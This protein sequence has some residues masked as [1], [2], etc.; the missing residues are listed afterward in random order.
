MPSFWLPI[1]LWEQPHDVC[2]E[3]VHK[4]ILD[5]ATS[6]SYHT[7]HPDRVLQIHLPPYTSQKQAL[8]FSSPPLP[9]FPASSWVIPPHSH[10]KFITSA[11]CSQSTLCRSCPSPATSR[12]RISEDFI[13]HA[14]TLFRTVS[15]L[16]MSAPRGGVRQALTFQGMRQ[17]SLKTLQRHFRNA[18]PKLMWPLLLPRHLWQL[19]LWLRHQ[20]CHCDSHFSPSLKTLLLLTMAWYSCSS[21]ILYISLLLLF[22]RHECLPAAI[23]PDISSHRKQEGVVKVI[24]QTHNTQGKKKTK[25]MWLS[26]KAWNKSPF[27]QPPQWFGPGSHGELSLNPLKCALQGALQQ[28]GASRFAT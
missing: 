26:W 10:Q 24:S 9:S 16:E 6:I 11:H 5:K 19:F 27:L 15:P 1:P 2:S 22:I 8:I 18:V 12:F 25:Q 20:L 4:S 3:D 17:L 23:M 28:L 13:I 21:S 14:Y 7:H